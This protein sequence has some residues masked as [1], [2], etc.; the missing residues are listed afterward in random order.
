MSTNLPP[1]RG[2]RYKLARAVTNG[3]I[4]TGDLIWW[5]RQRCGKSKEVHGATKEDLAGGTLPSGRFGADAA[6][7]QMLIVGFNLTAAMKRLILGEARV[8]KRF[9]AIRPWLINLLGRL[10]A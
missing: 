4:S 6:W 2:T 1:T 10:V 5:H 3:D 7:W 9:K 8:T